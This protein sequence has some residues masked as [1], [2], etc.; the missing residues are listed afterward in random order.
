MKMEAA[1]EDTEHPQDS[2]HFQNDH[3]LDKKMSPDP[4]EQIEKK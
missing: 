1:E 3:E 2:L 4:F